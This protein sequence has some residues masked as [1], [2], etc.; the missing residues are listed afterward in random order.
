MTPVGTRAAPRGHGRVRQ[1]AHEG[2]RTRILD[3][4]YEL[5]SL[6]GIHA[7]GI[8]RIIAEAPVAK[9]TLYHH[10][11]SKE[12]LVCAFLELREKRWT[13]EWLQSETE[14]LAARQRDRALTMFDVLGEW[15]RRPDFEGC[16]FI[17][18]LLEVSDRGDVVHRAAVHH[19]ETVRAIL[20]RYAEQAGVT[21]PSETAYRLQVLMMGA[22]VSARRG[23]AGAAPR[24]RAVAELLLDGSA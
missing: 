14:R 7:V 5:F 23:D 22:I 1:R 9:A 20:Q 15:F 21:N 11:A 2:A 4:A 10:F 19:L 17:N 24:A 12:D 3:A 8:D 13:F 18:T 16:S 6:H